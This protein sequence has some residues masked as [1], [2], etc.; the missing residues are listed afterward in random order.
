MR[1]RHA[2]GARAIHREERLRARGYK[3]RKILP[4]DEVDPVSGQITFAV[5]KAVI[6]EPKAEKPKAKKAPAKKKPAAK[7][8]A[9]PK[10]SDS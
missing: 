6:E 7:K 3:P 4:G 1:R 9:S 5:T 2:V 10:K 8:K